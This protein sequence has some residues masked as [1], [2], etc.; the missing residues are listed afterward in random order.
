MTQLKLVAD[1]TPTSAPPPWV[2]RFLLLMCW[3]NP[4]WPVYQ[5]RQLT[6]ATAREGCNSS[7]TRPPGR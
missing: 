3:L 1:A 2:K 5:S 7:A 6:D 4:W